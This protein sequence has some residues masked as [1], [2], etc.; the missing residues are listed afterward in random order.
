MIT[1]MSFITM[2]AHSMFSPCRR[3]F[4]VG[5][6]SLIGSSWA[7]SRLAAQPADPDQFYGPIDGEAFPVPA[8]DLSRIHPQY[9]RAYVPYDTD[10]APGTVVIDPARRYLYLT[11]GNGQAL[12][13]GV[14]VGRQ[15][16][17]WSGTAQ[18]RVKREWPDWYPPKEMLA[19]DPSIMDNMDK[20]QGGIGMPGGPGNPLG[21][22]AMYLW[23][24]NKDTLYRIHGTIEP[25]TIGS[26]IS[27]GCIRMINQDA[28]DLYR[29]VPV[30]TKVVVLSGGALHQAGTRRRYR[31]APP[32]V[33]DQDTFDPM[34]PQ[35]D[36]VY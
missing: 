23:Q 4:L 3:A 13:Y 20:L 11:D 1:A 22:R 31:N 32:P 21:A 35:P 15:G 16:F 9:L 12:R 19:R 36:Q 14:G 18:I 27:S 33:E 25:W 6:A 8:I 17:A 28:I 24:G 2:G 7:S 30:G 5:T 34:E 10:E 29:R 26:S